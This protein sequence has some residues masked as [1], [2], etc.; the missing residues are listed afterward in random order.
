MGNRIDDE[1]FK[2]AIAT[3]IDRFGAFNPFDPFDP[4]FVYITTEMLMD[5]VTS[6]NEIMPYD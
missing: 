3:Y 2:L 1:A 5:A 6:G 4:N